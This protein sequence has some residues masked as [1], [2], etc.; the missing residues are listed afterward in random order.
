MG[1]WK[2]TKLEKYEHKRS[3]LPSHKNKKQRLGRNSIDNMMKGI[4]QNTPLKTSKQKRMRRE[5]AE[6]VSQVS[7]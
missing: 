5:E 3:I 7:Y 4:I 6:H 1:D 2:K